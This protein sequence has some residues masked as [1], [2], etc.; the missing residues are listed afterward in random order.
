MSIPISYVKPSIL[1][2]SKSYVNKLTVAYAVP[3]D[4]RPTQVNT[5]STKFLRGI[6]NF[7]EVPSH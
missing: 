2:T 5:I 4:R 7:I 6:E 1:T 3:K